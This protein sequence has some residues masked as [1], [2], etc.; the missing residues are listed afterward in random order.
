VTKHCKKSTTGNNVCS[1]S[2]I[3]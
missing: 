3:I 1:V 2:V